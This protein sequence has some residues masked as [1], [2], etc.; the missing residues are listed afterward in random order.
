MAR[1]GVGF[2]ATFTGKKKKRTLLEIRIK[3]FHFVVNASFQEQSLG[4]CLPWRVMS[5]EAPREGV[6]TVRLIVAML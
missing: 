3:N 4:P 5:D 1:T 2:D 6:A